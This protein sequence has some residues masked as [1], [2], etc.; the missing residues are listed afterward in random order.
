MA[1]VLQ[2]EQTPWPRDGGRPRGPVTFDCEMGYTTLG[3]ELIRLTAVSWPQNQLLLDILVRPIGEVI[4]Y[5][6]RF[7]GVSQEHVS[8]ALPYGAEKP[9]KDDSLSEDGEL[10]QE[11]LRI[12]ESPMVARKLLF[13]LLTP[14][15]PLIGHAIENDLNT[16]RVIHPTIVDTVL[17]FPH[18]RGLPIRYGLKM[19]TSKYLERSIQTGGALGHDSKEDAIA[20]GELVRFKVGEKWKHMKLQGWTFEDARLIPP[21]EPA[22][23]LPGAPK[24]LKRPASQLEGS[25]E[26]NE[27]IA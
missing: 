2:F 21:V 3:L 17:L 11:P 24:A 6:T 8:K 7:S 1:S 20:T 9:K 18:P 12:V 10:E 14:E 25:V 5:N 26:E 15:T 16:C 4:D 22:K 13:E 19:L 23:K 27:R